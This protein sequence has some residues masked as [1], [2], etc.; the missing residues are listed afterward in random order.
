M[1]DKVVGG[2]LGVLVVDDRADMRQIFTNMFY[3]EEN[4][5]VVGT[6]ADGAEA[7]Q[8]AQELQPDIILMDVEMP[9]VDGIEAT[10]QIKEF[11]PG[12]LIIGM[13]T[14]ARHKTKMLVAGASAYLVKPF[15]AEEVANAISAS[16]AT[17]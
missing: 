16:Q 3:F 10:R 14:E 6:A 4:M 7:V 17:T 9:G 1:P 15:Q 12:V 8:M 2:K 13:S 5:Q 11:A